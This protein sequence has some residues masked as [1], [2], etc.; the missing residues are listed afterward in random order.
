MQSRIDLKSITSTYITQI[1]SIAHYTEHICSHL[2]VN[3]LV[4]SLFVLC[5]YFPQLSL[6]ILAVRIG[7]TAGLPLYLV[8]TRG[9]H[10]VRGRTVL[11]SRGVYDYS[12]EPSLTVPATMYQ[13]KGEAFL[14]K[15]C[16]LE[17][18]YKNKAGEEI[19]SQHIQ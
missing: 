1:R 5:C 14:S 18:M 4:V 15:K 13:K 16:K 12:G 9:S 8:L 6:H 10:V 19:V 11:G 2:I 3:L 17:V 7:N